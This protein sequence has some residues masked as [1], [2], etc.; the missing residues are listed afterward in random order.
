MVLS[1]IRVTIGC[2]VLYIIGWLDNRKPFKGFG[3]PKLVSLM[4]GKKE[5]ILNASG[6]AA[7]WISM[8]YFGGALFAFYKRRIDWVLYSG[9]TGAILAHII[10]G[11]IWMVWVVLRK[12]KSK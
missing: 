10:L 4:C 6:L 12:I 11:F 9:V 7:Q 1:I 8:G 2:M 5:P 3:V